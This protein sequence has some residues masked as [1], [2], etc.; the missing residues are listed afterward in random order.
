MAA[1]VDYNPTM[2]T[3]SM[4]MASQSPSNSLRHISSTMS[5]TIDR[6]IDSREERID[7]LKSSLIQ[8]ARTNDRRMV[9]RKLKEAT[10]LSYI[11][12]EPQIIASNLSMSKLEQEV[13]KQKLVL[14]GT[15]L[16]PT[17]TDTT[18]RNCGTNN[19]PLVI[20]KPYV[21]E[22]CEDTELNERTIYEGIIMRLER[23][24][25]MVEIYSILSSFMENAELILKEVPFDYTIKSSS[26]VM[27]K[28]KATN[29]GDLPDLTLYTTG[30]EIHMSLDNT[31]N[32]GLYRKSDTVVNRPWIILRCKVHERLNVSTNETFR[33]L[34]VKTP[35]LY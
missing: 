32:F 34:S 19:G 25:K 21:K 29:Y 1:Y 27:N 24:S 4:T 28:N 13:Y 20:L 9:M 2:A 14:N 35:E 22:L 3:A 12:L 10:F 16:K 11:P 5:S 31:F 17:S 30:S 23:S 7:K 15:L 33:S 26:Y 8:F 6:H 18:I